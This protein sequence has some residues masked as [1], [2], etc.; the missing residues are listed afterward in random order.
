MSLALFLQLKVLYHFVF[1]NLLWTKSCDSSRVLVVS[2]KEC[3]YC[4]CSWR[5][6]VPL[7][8]VGAADAFL[9]C[10]WCVWSREAGVAL[11]LVAFAVAPAAPATT[12]AW[13]SWPDGA[14]SCSGG[15]TG[16][17]PRGWPLSVC[18]LVSKG[19]RARKRNTAP[20]ERKRK[21]KLFKREWWNA[22]SNRKWL[23]NQ[24]RHQAK[25]ISFEDQAGQRNKSSP[26][27]WDS[28]LV[29]PDQPGLQ[30]GSDLSDYWGTVCATPSPSIS[31]D[32][33]IWSYRNE[34]AH[35][36]QTLPGLLHVYLPSVHLFCSPPFSARS[37]VLSQGPQSPI[38]P[39]C[40]SPAALS[41]HFTPVLFCPGLGL[42]T[43]EGDKVGGRG[44]EMPRGEHSV[45]RGAHQSHSTH[46]ASRGRSHT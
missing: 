20:I 37:R 38:S 29:G 31:A 17:V 15:A 42:A 18:L 10:L 5:A 19:Y 8:G 1:E 7:W 33:G 34:S 6:D 46:R 41:L 11:S 21:R 36:S 14:T 24:G 26:N 3:R 45:L 9:I 30:D 40:C 44:K 2:P 4:C 28:F 16:T 39:W 25:E 27:L 12:A 32:L 22:K 13:S 43:C 35:L 23:G